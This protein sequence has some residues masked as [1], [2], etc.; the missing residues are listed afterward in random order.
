[1]PK[2]ISSIYH[3]EILKLFRPYKRYLKDMLVKIET[4]IGIK[5]MYAAFLYK[6]NVIVA[7]LVHID[8]KI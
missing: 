8:M 3:T 2:L 7:K 4:I 5:H 1:M 6:V